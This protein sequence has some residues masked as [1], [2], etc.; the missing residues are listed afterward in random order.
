M[1][2][3]SELIQVAAV[4]LAAVQCED[5]GT[6]HIDVRSSLLDELLQEVAN[7]RVRQEMKWGP[8]SHPRA[9]WL[10]ILAEEFGEA[11]RAVLEDNFA[12]ERDVAT[13]P[14]DDTNSYGGSA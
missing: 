8:Q 5:S 9:W 3:R 13:I 12:H 1:S 14:W 2:Y 4:A 11:A 6:T 10:T 7:E